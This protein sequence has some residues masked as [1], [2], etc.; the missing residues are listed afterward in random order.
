MISSDRKLET[1]LEALRCVDLLSRE[2]HD[3][4]R[5]GLT[6]RRTRAPRRASVSTSASVPKRSMRLRRRPLTRGWDTRRSRAGSLCSRR[7]DAT[8]SWTAACQPCSAA[9]SARPGSPP[10]PRDNFLVDPTSVAYREDPHGARAALDRV[11]EPIPPDPVFPEPFE[12]PP[13]RFADRGILGHGTDRCLDTSLDLG[14]QVTHD[15]GHVGRYVDAPAGHY[16]ARRLGAT[17]RSPNTSSNDRPRRPR[18]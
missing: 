16:L 1:T 15:L 17:S 4:R 11:D 5:S 12:I 13:K 14:R 18:A 7:R 8:S 3:G 2:G 9:A 10:D 6:L